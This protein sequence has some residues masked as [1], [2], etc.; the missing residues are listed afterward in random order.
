MVVRRSTAA[1][2]EA[3]RSVDDIGVA[4]AFEASVEAAIARCTTLSPVRSP[5]SL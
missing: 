3:E 5:I 2:G 1:A 4:T